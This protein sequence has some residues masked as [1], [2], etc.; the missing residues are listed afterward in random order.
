MNNVSSANFLLR[1][2]PSKVVACAPEV[3]HFGTTES[4]GFTLAR[5]VAVP[6]TRFAHLVA[7][8]AKV[9][10][11][12]AAVTICRYLSRFFLSAQE[13]PNILARKVFMCP[14]DQADYDLHNHEG[15]GETL[16][17]SGSTQP[18]EGRDVEYP[19][20]VSRMS[21]G[22]KRENRLQLLSL[23]L[24]AHT[25]VLLEEA[26]GEAASRPRRLLRHPERVR[27]HRA[28]PRTPLQEDP[29]GGQLQDFRAELPH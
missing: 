9:T 17:L 6:S 4:D 7:A 14:L 2:S 27:G 18:S 19:Y 26:G 13:M 16:V 23:S 21:L 28:R 12:V 10:A 15:S 25:Q 1:V 24:G 8:M 3:L 20:K 11:T 29:P 22:N 5:H